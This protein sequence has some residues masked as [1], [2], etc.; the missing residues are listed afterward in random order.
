LDPSSLADAPEPRYPRR[1]PPKSITADGDRISETL[2]ELLET[3][4]DTVREV[5]GALVEAEEEGISLSDL[6]V[7]VDHSPSVVLY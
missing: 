7:S 4:S 3:E 5:Y 6:E 2:E 1:A